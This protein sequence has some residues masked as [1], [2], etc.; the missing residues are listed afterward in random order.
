[1]FNLFLSSYFNFKTEWRRDKLVEMLCYCQ[2][3]RLRP[4][5]N[6]TEPPGSFWVFAL[7]KKA[8]K[9]SSPFLVTIIIAEGLGFNLRAENLAQLSLMNGLG[10]GRVFGE[11]GGEPRPCGE[12]H[13][14]EGEQ[15]WSFGGIARRA[16]GSA[17]TRT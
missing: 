7:G 10:P 4:P 11:D 13:Q 17:A 12:L 14:V 2:T 15:R 9:P 1:M 3:E 6:R 5:N 16:A 8:S